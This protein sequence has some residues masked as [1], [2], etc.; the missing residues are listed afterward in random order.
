MD[1]HGF[2]IIIGVG[3]LSIMGVGLMSL[4]MAGSGFLVMNGR[5]HGLRGEVVA[6][7]T[8]GHLYRRV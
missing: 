6:I 8:D 7:T 4:R 2:L 3:L 5:L 1:G